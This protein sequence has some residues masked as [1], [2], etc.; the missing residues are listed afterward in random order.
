MISDVQ[1]LR[2]YWRRASVLRI[3]FDSLPVGHLSSRTF[4]DVPQSLQAN[5]WMMPHIYIYIYIYIFVIAIIIFAAIAIIL[6]HPALPGEGSLLLLRADVRCIRAEVSFFRALRWRR[7][8]VKAHDK[9]SAKLGI[10][11]FIEL[12]QIT[13]VTRWLVGRARAQLRIF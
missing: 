12:K 2:K 6:S 13:L 1:I 11:R 10:C 5:D 3:S 7:Q 4:R 8:R 9:A